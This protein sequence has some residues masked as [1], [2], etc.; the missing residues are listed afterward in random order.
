MLKCPKFSFISYTSIIIN[1][2]VQYFGV[3][4]CLSADSDLHIVRQ[5]RVPEFIIQQDDLVKQSNYI[6]IQ[7]GSEDASVGRLQLT[8]CVQNR[9]LYYCDAESAH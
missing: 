6:S 2:I 1:I 7:E 8:V 4:Y 3:I 5:T 9:E